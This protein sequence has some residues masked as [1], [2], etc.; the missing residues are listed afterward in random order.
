M[1]FPLR[2]VSQLFNERRVM[3]IAL[4]LLYRDSVARRGG[5]SPPCARR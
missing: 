2:D 1:E 3:R 5:C 4:D